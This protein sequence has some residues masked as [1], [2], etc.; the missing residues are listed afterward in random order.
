[1]R[2]CRPFTA[3]EVQRIVDHFDGPFAKRDK[4]VF[5]LGIKSGFR[6]SE[7]L[8]LR[9][10]EVLQHGR[11]VDRI[12]IQR[13][14][15]KGRIEGRTILLHPSAKAALAEWIDELKAAGPLAEQGH[16]FQSRK[17]ANGP[18]SRTHY[19]R[20]LAEV[21]VRCGLTGRLGT[22]SM[23]KTFAGRIYEKLNHDL[24]KTQRALGH[25]NINST[26]AYLSFKEEEI[27]EAIL[28]I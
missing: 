5:L 16:V 19:Y 28:G 21:C 8:S 15:M 20:I 3:K 9:I 14:S 18:I 27:D 7:L 22:H 4:A 2:G 17:G 24:V 6:I 11:I 10:G 23:R 25:R 13:R 26:A 1:M 12:T